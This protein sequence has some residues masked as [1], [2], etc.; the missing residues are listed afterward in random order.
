MKRFLAILLA[1]SML[2]AFTGCDLFSVEKVEDEEFD[3]EECL[4]EV[5]ELVEDGELEKAE[6]LLKKA[7]RKTDDEEEVEALEACLEMVQAMMEGEEYPQKETAHDTTAP[8]GATEPTQRPANTDRPVENGQKNLADTLDRKYLYKINVFLSNFAEQ[9]FRAYPCGDYELLMFGYMYA[10]VNNQEVLE[11]NSTHYYI[12]KGNMDS[13]LTRFFDR[14]VSLPN[15]AVL[16]E[17]NYP[18]TFQD[19]IYYF[20]GADGVSVSYCAV[21]TSMTEISL[22]TYDVAFDVYAHR[23]P[24]ESMAP[25]YELNGGEARNCADLEFQY[26]GNAVVRDY[27]RSNGV[28]SYQLISYS[29]S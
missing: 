27:V 14:T 25:Y 20:P 2:L 18:V 6:K 12:A 10:K 4:E 19:N 23:Y 1:M 17:R 22:G 15:G 8:T 5:E 16:D 29:H 28:E 11:N 7:L 13:I 21:V 24:H 9:G 26:S 3:L